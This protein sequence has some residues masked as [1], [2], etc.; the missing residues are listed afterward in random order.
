[1][2]FLLFVCSSSLW[3]RFYDHV[4]TVRCCCVVFKYFWLLL[5]WS[6]WL[7]VEKYRHVFQFEVGK[8]A[9][10]FS[11]HFQIRIQINNNKRAEAEEKMNARRQ[12]GS[13]VNFKYSCCIDTC[14]A[15]LNSPD[16]YLFIST[17]PSPSSF[18]KTL[19][20]QLLLLNKQTRLQKMRCCIPAIKEVCFFFENL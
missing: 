6:G 11:P 8:P 2:W 13:L 5:K 7:W 4:A 3:F 20:Q 10:L 16:D 9:R 12:K 14:C 1:M 15:A 17:R 19:Q 18:S